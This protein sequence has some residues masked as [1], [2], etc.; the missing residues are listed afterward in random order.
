M[1]E[2][3]LAV[4]GTMEPL[5]NVQECLVSAHTAGYRHFD[6]AEAYTTTADVGEWWRKLGASREEF[7]FTSKLKGGLPLGEYAAVKAQAEAHAKA[8]DIGHFDLLLIHYP[9]NADLDFGADGQEPN[10]TPE[11]FKE[12]IEQAWGN[13]LKLK[14][15]GI[16]RHIGVS[17]FYSGHLRVLEEVHGEHGLPFANQLYVD[18]SHQEGEFVAEMQKKDIKVMS[19]RSM[20]FVANVQMAGD[21]GVPVWGD[22][23]AIGGREAISKWLASRGIAVISKSASHAADNFQAV[24]NGVGVEVAFLPQPDE[25]AMGML[26]MVGAADPYAAMFKASQ[27]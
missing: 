10:C 21:M 20:A 24:A 16:T 15:D 27:P 8:L 11:F 19:Y 17:N 14:A 18:L 1:E 25:E 6:C 26:E 23:E 9:G 4:F 7:W 22:L 13:M 2:M 3:P 12:N 5:D